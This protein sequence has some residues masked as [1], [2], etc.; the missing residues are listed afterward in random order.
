MPNNK[1]ATEQRSEIIVAIE[2]FSQKVSMSL[3][4]MFFPTAAGCV[5]GTYMCCNSAYYTAADEVELRSGGEH[6]A[7]TVRSKALKC[8]CF[9]GGT[10][11][12]IGSLYLVYE[13]GPFSEPVQKKT[14]VLVEQPELA[15]TTEA[16]DFSTNTIV[17][18]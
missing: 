6:D 8:G 12:F 1:P 18:S 11:G 15:T 13:V 17:Q 7:G 14:E 3:F 16:T 5:I 10:V 9:S 2:D 4:M